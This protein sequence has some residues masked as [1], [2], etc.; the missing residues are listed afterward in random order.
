MVASGK[1]FACNAGDPGSVPVSGS[2][3]GEKKGNPLQYSCL[4]NPMDRGAWWATV[5]GVAKS[6]TRL[7][8]LRMHANIHMNRKRAALVPF[9]VE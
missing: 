4:E 1:E 6:R 2:S 9:G 8:R 7:N 5:H 3:P